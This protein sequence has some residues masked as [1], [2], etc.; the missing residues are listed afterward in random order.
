MQ[1]FLVAIVIWT[2]RAEECAANLS[3]Y[4][5]AQ[6]AS[7][8][9]SR[10]SV[11]RIHPRKTK[12]GGAIPGKPKNLTRSHPRKTKELASDNK[13]SSDP[14][15]ENAGYCLVLPDAETNF[16]NRSSTDLLDQP[17]QKQKVLI[18][19]RGEAMRVGQFGHSSVDINVG[20]EEQLR[21]SSSHI[22][23]LIRPLEAQYQVFVVG[24]THLSNVGVAERKQAQAR[25]E[26]IQRMYTPWLIRPFFIATPG[27]HNNQLSNW[28][29]AWSEATNASAMKKTDYEYKIALRFDLVLK[30]DFGK[31]LVDSSVP[32]REKL[33]VPFLTGSCPYQHISDMFH[34]IPAWLW[35]HVSETIL[36]HHDMGKN[37]GWLIGDIRVTALLEGPIGECYAKM[38]NPG[39]EP[40]PLYTLAG[41]PDGQA[42]DHGRHYQGRL[43]CYCA[44]MD[45]NGSVL[46]HMRAELLST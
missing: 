25:L 37:L 9:Q 12:E 16:T 7:L 30:K 6:G 38:N 5:W 32:T 10:I 46:E 39:G 23:K 28:K 1:T 21:A 3:D 17:Q 24:A 27:P 43:R 22:S 45:E 29:D 33:I 42:T 15:W 41:R 13:T 20:F 18:V 40:N 34:W 11:K 4:K 8:A 35:P 26:D 36:D 19:L 2:G 44:C 31:M 14:I